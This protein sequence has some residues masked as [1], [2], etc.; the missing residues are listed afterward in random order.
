MSLDLSTAVEAAARVLYPRAFRTMRRKE[1]EIARGLGEN[2]VTAAVSHIERQ[3]REQAAQEIEAEL[4][5]PGLSR[6]EHD[7]YRHAIRIVRGGMP[8]GPTPPP[9]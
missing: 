6:I 3:V 7:T 2:A 5:R 8:V 1:L 9:G 4:Q